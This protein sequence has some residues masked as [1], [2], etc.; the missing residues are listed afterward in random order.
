M[1][2]FIYLSIEGLVLG[3]LAA[4]AII[5]AF[6]TRITYPDI[7]LELLEH[8]W[9]GI[10]I[11]LV[12]ILI[13]RFS[14]KVASLILILL[15]AF[16]MD[17]IIFARPLHTIPTQVNDTN[18]RDYTLYPRDYQQPSSSFIPPSPSEQLS[19]MSAQF[20]EPD[21]QLSHITLQADSQGP[22][23]N[24]VALPVPVYPVFHAPVDQVR[25]VAAPF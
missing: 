4:L 2:E 18:A 15:F 14:P 3:A 21:L 5:Y 23:L 9:I 8:P 6:Q 1:N 19:H 16:Y 13:F 25:G 10:I 17:T 11:F 24:S 7:V 22:S 20:A 12:S